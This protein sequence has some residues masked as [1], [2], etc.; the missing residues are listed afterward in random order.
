MLEAKDQGHSD[1][2]ASVLKKTKRLQIFYDD[3][4]K[5]SDSKN[6]AVLEQRT[7]LFSRT[8]G[9]EAKAKNFEMCSR[10]VHLCSKHP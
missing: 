1:T 7:G 5:F 2:G 3:L 6:S 8:S 9:L 10:G 4:Q